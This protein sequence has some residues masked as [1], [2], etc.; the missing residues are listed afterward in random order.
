M[1]PTFLEL[2]LVIFVSLKLQAVC[3]SYS[4]FSVSCY[5]DIVYFFEKENV[6]SADAENCSCFVSYFPAAEATLKIDF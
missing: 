1:N 3:V 5:C 6:L 2:V 4:L